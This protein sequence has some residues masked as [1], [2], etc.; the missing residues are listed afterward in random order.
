MENESAMRKFAE[1]FAKKLKAGDVIELLGD[2]GSGK[3]FFT[4]A[5]SESLG[6]RNVSSPSFV[7][8]N[9]YEGEKFPIKHFDFYRLNDPG[10]VRE[11]L[12]ENLSS[13]ALVIIEWAEG[14]KGV[15]PQDRYIIKFN[16]TGTDSR[17]LTIHK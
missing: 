2:V 7:I 4:R 16:V 9:E 15:L 12:N 13:L 3:T 5:L 14:V 8:K 17:E 11:E 1:N 10:I 6:A